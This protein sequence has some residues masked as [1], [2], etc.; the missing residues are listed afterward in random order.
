MRSRLLAL[1]VGGLLAALTAA[2]A[3]PE[4]LAWWSCEGLTDGKLADVS[5][6]GH[7]AT[8]AGKDGKLPEAVPGIA[9]KALQFDP[10]AEQFLTVA[11]DADLRTPP[12]F[13]VMAWIKPV[14]RGG[15]Y[16]II[17][18]KGDRDATGPGTGWRLRYFW[19]RLSFEFATAGAELI[20]VYSPEWSVMAGHWAHV[21][22]TYDGQ[23][24]QLYVNA[25]PVATREA[26]G[27]IAPSA[28]EIVIANYVGR[29]NAYPF[30][31]L[32]DEVKV[33]PA[34]LDAEGIFAEAVRNME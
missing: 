16:E 21:A 19:S 32:L 1:M 29:K 30:T 18:N 13:T 31:G 23:T 6:H 28:R 4:P 11:N 24:V 26:A 25:E 27:P 5:G 34:I 2:H 22:A 15:T 20:T 10:A 17:G 7:D 8:V 12:A 14:A 3:A 33:F 9:G